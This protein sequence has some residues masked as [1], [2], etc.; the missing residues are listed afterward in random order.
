M[1]S[2]KD[3]LEEKL[4]L[5]ANWK[6]LELTDVNKRYYICRHDQL[7]GT[8]IISID[9]LSY[10]QPRETPDGYIIYG[11]TGSDG[12]KHCHLLHRL[13]YIAFVG[14]IPLGK[15]IDHLN[16]N[17]KDNSIENLAV[18][19]ASEQARNRQ[20]Y[21]QPG[22]RV[23]IV[24]VHN[25]TQTTTEFSSISEAAK[26]L[27]L[28]ASDISAVVTERQVTSH[29]YSFSYKPLTP[30][31]HADGKQET[32]TRLENTP[33]LWVSSIPNR[34]SRVRGGIRIQVQHKKADS[35]YLRVWTNDRKRKRLHRIL[36]EQ[37]LGH[38]LSSTIDVDHKNGNINDN[39]EQNL[40]S[41]DRAEHA[42]KTHARR[43]VVND[44]FYNSLTEA[45]QMRGISRDTITRWIDSNK[46]G[47]CWATSEVSKKRQRTKRRKIDINAWP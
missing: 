29:G 40:Q 17:R 13:R 3:R 4:R 6:L 36:Y 7:D 38:G 5:D 33:D 16:G 9:S 24:A 14:E 32:W 22:N 10:L 18:A 42:L 41:L 27:N 47:C 23:A 34:Y 45:A 1:L 37:R 11:F 26:T 28:K 21:S 25:A 31:F 19:T 8:D 46:D 12:K 2:N 20:K 35:E 30:E 44:V 39:T 43:C 15:T